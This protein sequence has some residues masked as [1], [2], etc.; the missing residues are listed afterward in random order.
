MKL[1]VRS[2]GPWQHALDVEIP[3]ED[4][5]ARFHELAL[6]IQRR[7]ALP[8]FRKG[9]VPLDMVR[10]QFAPHL[11]QDF[12]EDV[13]PRYASDAVAEARLEPVVP[14]TVRNLRLTPGAPL[15]FEVHVEVR[16]E[17]EVRDYRG[18][19]LTRRPVAIDEAT[20]DA[21]LERLR[22]ESA[23]F[24]DLSRPAQRGDV[25]LVDTVRLDPNGR[26][27]GPTRQKGLRLQLGAPGML[28]D[29]ENG[30]LGAEEGQER[31]VAI[32]YPADY[33]NA[34]LAGKSYRYA[35]KVRKIQEKKLRDLDDN[36]A[37]DVFQLGTLDELRARVR[38]NLEAEE[39]V[40]VQR[41]LDAAVTDELI[42]RNPVEL[43]ERL[44]TWMLARVIEEGTGG[45]T[46]DDRLRADLEAR[47]RPGVERSLRREVLLAAVAKQEGLEVGDADVAAEIERM[48]QAEPRQASRIRARY[49]S[50]DRRRALR[51][52]L[53]ERKAL[54]RLIEL[55][56][57]REVASGEPLVVPAGR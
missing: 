42:R 17:V 37:R 44:V 20:V 26:R 9:R 27:L 13:V 39:R 15:T 5:E 11:E 43:P 29:L 31:T 45:R 47:Y 3:V 36:F 16:P 28:P 57:V 50:E 1:S 41:E 54:D 21:A 6:K 4:V 22:E 2:T 23:V 7:A 8:G 18:L 19:P 14:P 33:A 25:L 46:M 38:A 53:L 35:V 55:A 40:R 32:D 10:A 30:L 12:V 48:I 24:A 49:Q 52:G 34:E 56:E 51:E